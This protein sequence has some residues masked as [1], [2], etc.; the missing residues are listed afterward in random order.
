MGIRI[1]HTIGPLGP[2]IPYG[3]V[4]LLV[5][6]LGATTV[7]SYGMNLLYLP[8]TVRGLDLLGFHMYGSEACQAELQLSWIQSW[9]KCSLGAGSCCMGMQ[10]SQQRMVD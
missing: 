5:E 9:N 8:L 3:I 1:V 2:Y 6:I 10:N 7:I 4:L